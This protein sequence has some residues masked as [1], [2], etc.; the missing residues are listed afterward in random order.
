[1]RVAVV[2]ALST[3]PQTGSTDLNA[4]HVFLYKCLAF[5]AIDLHVMTAVGVFSSINVPKF[6]N[7]EHIHS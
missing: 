6:V 2:D 7:D 4:Y 5:H 1:M 3:T